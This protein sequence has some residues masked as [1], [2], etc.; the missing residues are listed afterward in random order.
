MN[1]VSLITNQNANKPIVKLPLYFNLSSHK[2]NTNCI[3]IFIKMKEFSIQTI[4][5]STVRII[6]L[7]ILSPTIYTF[8]CHTICTYPYDPSGYTPGC[9]GDTAADCVTCD[10][11]YFTL[12][13]QNQCDLRKD[14]IY[15]S[16]VIVPD[17]DW[18]MMSNSVASDTYLGTSYVKFPS[19][20]ASTVNADL[21]VK[22]VYAVR[23]RIT[24][25]DT[26][27]DAS[28]RLFAS[29]NSYV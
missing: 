24:F 10:T 22:G 14:A 13:I 3:L 20:G 16:T 21:V 6:L 1:N 5:S 23:I 7:F 28:C 15:N 4:P 26:T 25:I 12:S 29:I 11:N 17:A 2:I 18:I 27:A 19:N 9:S 8:F